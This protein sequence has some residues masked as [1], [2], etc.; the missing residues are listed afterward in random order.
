MSRMPRA[1]SGAELALR[2][3]LHAA[4]LRFRVNLSGLPGR[5][6]VVFTR[7]RIA[8]FVDGCFWHACPDHGTLPKNNRDWWQAKLAA[9]VERDRR[10][11]RELTGAGWVVVHVWEHEDPSAAAVRIAALWRRRTGGPVARGPRGA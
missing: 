4:G 8:C 3:A 11:D 6:D 10:K 7:A 1:G 2:R 9:N 5:P